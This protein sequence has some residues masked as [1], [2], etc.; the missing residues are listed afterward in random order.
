MDS[1]RKS[2]RGFVVIAVTLSILFLLGVAGLAVDIGRMYIAKSE[3]Q[4]FCDAA[5]IS[6]A[7]KL[8]GTVDGITAAQ[9]AVTNSFQLPWNFGLDKITTPQVEFATT[10]AGPWSATPASPI[11]ITLA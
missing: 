6:A 7:V 3:A 4:S 10:A 5:A 8:D 2:Q 1:R 9:T 11:G